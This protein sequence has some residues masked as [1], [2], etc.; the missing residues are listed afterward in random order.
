MK[1]EDAWAQLNRLDDI[2]QKLEIDLQDKTEA[3]RID[4]DQIE[5]TE[6]SGGLSHKPDPTKVRCLFSIY[7]NLSTY[8]VNRNRYLGIQKLFLTLFLSFQH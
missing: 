2:R 5:L 4:M 3:L 7:V 8:V 1:C 6:R